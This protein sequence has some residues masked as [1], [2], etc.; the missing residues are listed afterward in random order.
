MMAL[1]IGL[2]GFAGA[3]SRYGMNLL[4]KNISGSFPW[5]TMLVNIAGSFLI[6]IIFQL[7]LQSRID[8]RITKTL[9]VGVMGGFTTFSSFSLETLGLLE[10]GRILFAVINAVISV[11]ACIFAAWLGKTLVRGI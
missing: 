7:S 6:G 2:G 3:V 9:M 10:D 5:G 1:L 11:A 8:E 4:T